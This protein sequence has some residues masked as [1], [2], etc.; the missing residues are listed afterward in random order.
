MTDQE[1]LE[2][3]VRFNEICQKCL[4]GINSAKE[5]DPQAVCAAARSI[6][7]ACDGIVKMIETAE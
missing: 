2:A 4:K 6:G 3:I 5:M 1:R 7:D